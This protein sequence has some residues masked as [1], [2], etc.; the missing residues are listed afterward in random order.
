MPDIG[1]EKTE[2]LIALLELRIKKEY[3]QSVDELKEKALEYFVAFKKK[4]K[5]WR[6]RLETGEITQAEYNSWRIG[7]L[8]VGQRWLQLRDELVAILLNSRET[9]L[10][11][12]SQSAAKAYAVNYNYMTYAIERESEIDTLYKVIN[13]AQADDIIVDALNAHNRE[14]AAKAAETAKTVEEI[15]AAETALTIEESFTI[16]DL[17]TV[18][19]LM[20]NDPDMLPP[21]GKKVAADIAAGKAELWDVQ[22][23]QSVAT[24][25]IL[26][27]EGAD[28]IAERLAE[29]IGDSDMKAAI[30]NA[31]TMMT[32]AQ[33]A[34]RQ[35]AL[36]RSQNVG[37][38]NTKVWSATLDGRTRHEHRLL[39]G[40]RRNPDE[41]FEV[42]GEKIRYPG[43][44]DAP[45]H[46][47]WNCRCTMITQIEGFEYDIRSEEWLLDGKVRYNEYYE[48]EEKD[49]KGKVRYYRKK[50]LKEMT[51]DVW[52]KSKPKI[53][54]RRKG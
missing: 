10:A 37:I 26:Q 46:L 43:D 29:K 17:P 38:N 34:G 15:E 47:V 41:A 33:N 30:R 22:Q 36:T 18:E 35:D 54:R 32:T 20:I 48:V 45:P 14:I 11:M 7:Q 44:L 31:R 6:E 25:S 1:A 4:D 39:D 50:E 24:Q 2:E 23:I 27:G 52:K 53:N 9:A 13:E 51:Y 40:Q 3:S 8:I 16:Y 42:E 12:T 49:K 19:R 21:P 28:Q 5:T